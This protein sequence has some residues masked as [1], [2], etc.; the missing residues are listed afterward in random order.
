MAVGVA[1]CMDEGEV[2]GWGEPGG[3]LEGADGLVEVE[4]GGLE[5]GGI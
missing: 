1:G 2:F 5:P 3:F 4:E